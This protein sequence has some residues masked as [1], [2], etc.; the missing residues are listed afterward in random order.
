VTTDELV[1]RTAVVTDVPISIFAEAPGT[2][3]V[4]EFQV[5]TDVAPPAPPAPPPEGFC[6]PTKPGKDPS[7]EDCNYCVSCGADRPMRA[8]AAAADHRVVECAVC[9]APHVRHA[10]G[11]HAGPV[12]ALPRFAIAPHEKVTTRSARAS[13]LHFRR[14]RPARRPRPHRV[15]LPGTGPVAHPLTQIVGMSAKERQALQARRLFTIDELAL[16]DAAALA[17]ILPSKSRPRAQMLIGLA[18][19][20]LDRQ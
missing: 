15:P 6:P 18:R 7:G 4:S 1:L 11:V 16:L 13:A 10:G 20:W 2:L 5:V 19:R 3:T 12:T 14:M 8:H 17:A 9:R